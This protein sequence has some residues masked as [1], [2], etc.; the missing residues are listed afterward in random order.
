MD[1]LYNGLGLF[2]VHLFWNAC[3][4]VR[5][6]VPFYRVILQNKFRR[7]G[8]RLFVDAAGFI[9]KIH[10]ASLVLYVISNKDVDVCNCRQSS[11][12]FK[13][14]RERLNT[15]RNDCLALRL[16]FYSGYVGF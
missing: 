1:T 8:A 3:I 14:F 2:K 5:I 7:I 16:I 15:E 13:P 10:E 11:I 12:R 9:Q 6:L 4:A